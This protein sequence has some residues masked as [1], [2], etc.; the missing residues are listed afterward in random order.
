MKTTIQDVQTAARQAALEREFRNEIGLLDAA[1][2]TLDQMIEEDVRQPGTVDGAAI[3]RA[4]G[5]RQA[6][7]AL[8]I[9]FVE[10]N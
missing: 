6:L 10:N 1:V 2:T 4:R 3:M 9:Q 5:L 8:T 7:D